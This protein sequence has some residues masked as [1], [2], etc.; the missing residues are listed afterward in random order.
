MFDTN[1]LSF[2]KQYTTLVTLLILSTISH[3]QVGIG[4]S[5]PAGSSQ[6]DITSTTKGLLPPRMTT[7]QRD[8]ISA[9]AT[10]LQ[11]YN[12]D[13]RAIE[14]YTGTSGE[15]LTL[16]RGK[17]GISNN[18]ALGVRTLN[19]NTTGSGNTANGYT[20][21]FYNT[22]GSYH[23]ANGYQSLYSN[24]TGSNNTATGYQ[25]LYS[26]TTGSNNTATGLQSLY[27]NTTGYSNTANG[28]RTLYSNTTGYENSSLGIYALRHN[29]TGYKNTAIGGL[30]LYYNISGYGND[31]FGYK[32]LYANTYGDYNSSIG[33]QSLMANTT[34]NYNTA[35][36]VS[37][38]YSNTTGNG[39]TAVGHYTLGPSSS[40]SYST[41]IGYYASGTS[42]NYG[43][44]TGL[45]AYAYPSATYQMRIGGTM[46]TSIR[47]QVGWTST[48][49]ARVK[50]NIK[51]NVPGLSFV[52]KL[53]PVTYT[54]NTKKQDKFL[55]QNQSDS[56]KVKLM[57]PESEYEASSSII[58]TGF[59]AQEVEKVAKELGFDFDG[60]DAPQNENSL[61]GIRYAEFVVPLVKAIQEQQSIIENL[62]KRIE[63]LEE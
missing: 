59:V 50:E 56:M 11:I 34:G 19:S 32:A 12:T 58:R 22:T 63:K 57:L 20:A 15:W 27:P 28:H 51:E 17:A 49:D 44:A 8:A 60:V 54:I 1:K 47:G 24:T 55:I 2:M 31:A 45:G 25:S 10:G 43:Y 16:G 13:N 62:Q 46:I 26:N 21:L 42:G 5:S 41:A 14:T 38:L 3:A 52:T 6:L 61:Y 35:A 9:P 39:N 18:T 30:S 7:S 33:T 4:T 48:S 23:T 40:S 29:T 36:G 53:R 37:A